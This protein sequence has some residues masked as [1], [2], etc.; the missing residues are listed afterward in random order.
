MTITIGGNKLW[1]GVLILLYLCTSFLT[2]VFIDNNAPPA[3]YIISCVI[4]G[5]LGMVTFIWQNDKHH[6]VRVV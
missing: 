1:W 2:Y 3:V 4:Y 5:V 6:W